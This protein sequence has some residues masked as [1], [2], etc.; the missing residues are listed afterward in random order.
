MHGRSKILSLSSEVPPV[1]VAV[2]MVMVAVVGNGDGRGSVIARI[3][4]CFPGLA[5]Y[6]HSRVQSV[7][8]CDN[9]HL[10]LGFVHE[11]GGRCGNGVE[12]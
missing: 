4:R 9:G 3:C 10:W 5:R 11:G 1:V 12:M 7:V 8:K 6:E 2:A